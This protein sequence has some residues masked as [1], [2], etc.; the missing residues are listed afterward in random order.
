MIYSDE[1]KRK[2]W[3]GIFIY[4]EHLILISLL[5]K[6]REQFSDSKPSG[7]SADNNHR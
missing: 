5:N 7:P 3:F 6:K 2:Y 4:L 1:V